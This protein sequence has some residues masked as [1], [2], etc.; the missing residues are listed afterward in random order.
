MDRNWNAG[1]QSL[2]IW[3]KFEFGPGSWWCSLIS[4][5]VTKQTG[6]PTSVSLKTL[7]VFCVPG[8]LQSDCHQVHLF[9]SHL[10]WP[11]TDVL[12]EM[13]ET[14]LKRLAEVLFDLYFKT[15]DVETTWPP[16][17]IFT[18]ES[19][20]LSLFFIGF[21]RTSQGLQ[22]CSVSNPSP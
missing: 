21:S 3:G 1:S 10:R 11:V 22:L 7:I 17:R 5:P 14:A 4:N 15:L 12:G 6:N 18:T 16:C 8:T 20:L 19:L 9:H 2:Q 13:Q